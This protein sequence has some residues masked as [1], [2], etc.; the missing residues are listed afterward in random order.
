MLNCD[1]ELEE[2]LFKSSY[3]I[4]SLIGASAKGAAIFSGVDSNVR[5]LIASPKLRE[6]IESELCES[7]SLDETTE[8]VN[9]CGGI[10]K[11]QELVREKADLAI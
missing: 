10:E 2:C 8:L 1:L 9:N 3:K 5:M 4:A 6:I 7:G 11:A